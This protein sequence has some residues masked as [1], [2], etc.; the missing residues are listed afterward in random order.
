MTMENRDL[1]HRPITCAPVRYATLAVGFLCLGLGILGMFL[2]VMPT[3]V[4]LLIALWCFSRSSARVQR[5]LYEHP[6]LGRS[7]REWH[8]HRVIPPKAKIA[9]LSMMATSFL[10]TLYVYAG[11]WIVPEIVG[12]IL[13]GVAVFILRCPSRAPA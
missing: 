6:R 13:G 2:P 9:A 8:R 4:F 11:T 10:L 5:W 7:L 1:Q 12:V 3:T